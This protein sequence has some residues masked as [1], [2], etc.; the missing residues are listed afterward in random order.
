MGKAKPIDSFF[1]KKRDECEANELVVPPEEPNVH[2][3]TPL[4]L[5]EFEQQSYEEQVHQTQTN[6]VIFCGIKSLERDPALRPQICQYPANQRD[7]VRRA[8]LKLGPM[9]PDDICEMVKKYYPADFTH[10]EIYGLEQQFKHFVV[11][12]S[13]DDELKNVSTLA[14]LCRCLVES[15]RHSIYNLI[16][17]LLRLLLTLPVSTDFLL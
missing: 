12:A 6:D 13:N 15:G 9:Q 2:V 10:Q 17:R 1:R 14:K 4:L 3:Q 16:D 11:N 5:L 7:Y 8:Y